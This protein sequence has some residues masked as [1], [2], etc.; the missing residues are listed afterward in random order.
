MKKFEFMLIYDVQDGNPNG[1]P[2]DG[3]NPRIDF[4]TQHGLVSDVCLKR[5]VRDFIQL[6]KGG[7][8]GVEPEPGYELFVKPG[9]PLNNVIRK[10][11]ETGL[12]QGNKEAPKDASL[13]MDEFRTLK[14]K[15]KGKGKAGEDEKRVK[16]DNV[17]RIRQLAQQYLC[18]RF[19]DIRLFG[20]VVSTGGYNIPRLTGAFQ[21]TMSRSVDPVT[22][23]DI[24]M[25][26]CVATDEKEMKGSDNKNTKGDD[27][28]ADADSAQTP[29]E[30]DDKGVK[31]RT[32]GTKGIVPYGLYVM[33]GFYNPNLA[34]QMGVTDE[35]VSLV[36]DALK[37]AMWEFDRSS[38]RGLMATRKLIVFE[39]DEMLGSCNSADL[40]DRVTIKRKDG[41]ECA[42]SFS[43]YEVT[44]DRE[45]LPE[46]VTIK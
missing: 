5:K 20:G 18:E 6:V 38:G 32:F 31:E 12:E 46:G 23:Q 21:F 45:G 29:K 36:M 4:E 3:N 13:T 33:K 22:I 37:G 39:H 9:E 42:R 43:D 34:K 14:F 16:W 27:S 24:Q 28:D 15:I 8:S 2:N 41:V 7:G 11:A 1:D 44:I 19:V 30:S 25:T 10:A 40:F 26:R 35:D 17:Y